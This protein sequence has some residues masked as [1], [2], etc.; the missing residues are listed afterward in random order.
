MTRNG[1]IRIGVLR[2]HDGNFAP[3]LIPKHTRR[4]MRLEDKV[5]WTCAGDTTVRKIQS[6]WQKQHGTYHHRCSIESF[7]KSDS[8]V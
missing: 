6:F 2:H 1:F 7:Q 4:F 3:A 8:Y 5:L